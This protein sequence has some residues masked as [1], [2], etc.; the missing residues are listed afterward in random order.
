M[1]AKADPRHSTLALLDHNSHVRSDTSHKDQL[2]G[3]VQIRNLWE[4]VEAPSPTSGFFA[5][6]NWAELCFGGDSHALIL[7]S[8]ILIRADEVCTRTDLISA[9]L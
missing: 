6:I 7:E 8:G 2:L 4:I 1:Q 5:P 9:A 3:K